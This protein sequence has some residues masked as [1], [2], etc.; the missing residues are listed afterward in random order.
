LAAA[1]Q[2]HSKNIYVRMP[3]KEHSDIYFFLGGGENIQIG[4]GSMISQHLHKRF[5]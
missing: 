3:R 4:I 2:L 5:G 1:L